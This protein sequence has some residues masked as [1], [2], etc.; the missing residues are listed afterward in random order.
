MEKIPKSL[1][2]RLCVYHAAYAFSVN[3]HCN[4]LN[5]KEILAQNRCDMC[6]LSDCN[7]TCLQ[8]KSFWVRVL[9]QTLNLQISRLFWARCSLAFRH[10]EY[11][12]TLN[13]ITHS[14]LHHTHV[15]SQNSPIMW[16]VWIYGRLLVYK[17]R[18]RVPLQSLNLFLGLLLCKET[19][20]KSLKI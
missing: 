4:C 12:F 5:V 8:T 20:P 19:L 10:L 11:R 1:F 15:Q 17:I 6:N 16:S 14:Q 9:F 13:A 7:R 3:L 2:Q 18:R